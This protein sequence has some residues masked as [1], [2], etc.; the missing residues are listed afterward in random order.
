[1]VP[2]LR[3]STAWLWT[4]PF[5]AALIFGAGPLGLDCKRRFLM[6]RPSLT[7]TRQVKCSHGTPHGT[8]GQAGQGQAGAP[9]DLLAGSELVREL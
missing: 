1:M 4:Q 2:H 8:P 9:F 7:C 5:R 6:F 3:R